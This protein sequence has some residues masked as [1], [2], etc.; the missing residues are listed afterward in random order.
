MCIGPENQIESPCVY[1]QVEINYSA[2]HT[3]TKKNATLRSL[4][5]SLTVHLQT[6]CRQGSI[7]DDILKITMWRPRGYHQTENQDLDVVHQYT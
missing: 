5:V 4:S 6:L 2:S 7:C 1:L 3:L